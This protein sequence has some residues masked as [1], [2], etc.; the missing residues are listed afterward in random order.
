MSVYEVVTMRVCLFVCMC[1]CVRV[2]I[3]VCARACVSVVSVAVSTCVEAMCIHNLS[4]P[5]FIICRLLIKSYS[6]LINE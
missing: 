6:E 4:H 3:C 5:R 2:C 1:A